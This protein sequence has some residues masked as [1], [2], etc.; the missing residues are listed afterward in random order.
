MGKVEKQNDGEDAGDRG[1]SWKGDAVARD[2]AVG[3]ADA[4][5]RPGITSGPMADGQVARERAQG[6]SAHDSA[7]PGVHARRA[8]RSKRIRPEPRADRRCRR[9]LI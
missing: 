5:D 4:G 1:G 8:T 6:R 9:C 7:R 3:E 2:A